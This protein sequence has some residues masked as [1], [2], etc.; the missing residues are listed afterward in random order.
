MAE[1]VRIDFDV[2]KGYR[3]R[4]TYGTRTWEGEDD[5]ASIA[6]P[7]LFIASRTSV[8]DIGPGGGRRGGGGAIL[9]EVV[10][11]ANDQERD[12]VGPNEPIGQITMTYRM[13]GTDREVTQST[14]V[15]NTLT[16]GD[17]PEQG[18]FDNNTV[19]K[20]FVT[21]NIFMGFKLATERYA[22]GSARR[23]LDILEPLEENAQQWLVENPDEDIEDDLETMGTLIKTLEREAWQENI[24]PQ[25]APNPWPND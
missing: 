25:P 22:S 15:I 11:T 5:R 17:T 7:G 12:S 14:T 8:D 16:P 18:V 6:I 21:L 9:F 10:P 19:E 24:A 20:A 23:A 13:P 2:A 1:D 4:A 3:F